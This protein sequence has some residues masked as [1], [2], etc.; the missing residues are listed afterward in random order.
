M[1]T[2]IKRL[3]AGDVNLMN[4]LILVFEDVFETPPPIERSTDAYLKNL[5]AKEDFVVFV[6]LHDG[7]VVGGVTAYTLPQYAQMW[8]YGY[9]FDLAVKTAFQ[10]RGIGKMLMLSL[11]DYCKSIGIEEVFVQAHAEDV[12]AVKFYRALD[13]VPEKVV[14]FNFP[15]NV[16]GQP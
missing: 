12:H 2:Q 15:L 4:E 7:Q 16:P 8:R 6:A 1:T 11:N 5:L 13:G 10:R 14:H 9:V 3:S